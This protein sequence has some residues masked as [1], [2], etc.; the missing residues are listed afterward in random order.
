MGNQNNEFERLKEAINIQKIKA[1]TDRAITLY[2]CDTINYY[3]EYLSVASPAQED[4]ANKIIATLYNEIEPY[5]QQIETYK[6]LFN[7]MERDALEYVLNV[8]KQSVQYV[9]EYNSQQTSNKAQEEHP[10]AEPSKRGRQTKPF[11]SYLAKGDLASLHKAMEG[12]AGKE[13]ALIVRTAIQEG[14]ISKPTFTAV[15]KEFG[16]IGNRSGYNKYMNDKYNF[17]E[18]EITGAKKQ[19]GLK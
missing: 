2:N 14:L 19:L 1:L 10:K 5:L 6:Q 7:E 11:A 8:Y 9:L 12:K 16:D 4:E 18:D 17:S 15:K 3:G 13:A